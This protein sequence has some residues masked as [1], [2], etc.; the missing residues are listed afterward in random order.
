MSEDIYEEAKKRV[1]KKKKF[2]SDLSS[3]LIWSAILL[4]IN[5]FITRGYL[6]S[7]WVIGFWG[8]GIFQKSIKVYGSP[9]SSPDWEEK[10]IE[11]EM[12][13]LSKS[14]FPKKKEKTEVEND[15][16]KWNDDELV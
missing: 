11:K 16:K 2:H 3:Y 10:E 15:E 8:L 12:R 1:E 9:F 13:R 5:F 7:L 4:F 6:W 14:D